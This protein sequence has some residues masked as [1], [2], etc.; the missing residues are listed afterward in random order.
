M[1]TLSSRA[2]VTAEYSNHRSLQVQDSKNKSSNEFSDISMTGQIKERST[3][4]NRTK[5]KIM[6]HEILALSNTFT[7]TLNRV[8]DNSNYWDVLS[9]ITTKLTSNASDTNNASGV[10]DTLSKLTSAIFDKK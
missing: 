2:F 3:P 7:E 6:F 8:F 9:R 4:N 1:L 5:E 10:I